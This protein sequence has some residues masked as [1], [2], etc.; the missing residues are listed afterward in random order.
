[1]TPPPPPSSASAP[2][3]HHLDVRYGECDQQGV[4]FN[5]NYLAYV[6]DALDHWLRSQDQPPGS[7]SW[8]LMVKSAQLLWHSGATWPDRLDISCGVSRWGRTSF[9]VVYRVRADDRPIVDV[10]LVYVTIETGAPTPTPVA[11]PDEAR[12][13]FGELVPGLDDSAG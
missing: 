12:A 11:M 8:D 1:M 3:T 13:L 4:V 6:D 2:F 5:A 10:R 7:Q 9:D